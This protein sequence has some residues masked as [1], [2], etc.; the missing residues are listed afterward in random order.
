MT[1]KIFADGFHF[2]RNENAPDFVIGSLSVNVEQS[3]DT[4]KNHVK[5]GWL[6][7]Q[8]KLSKGGKYYVEVD[9]WEPGQSAPAESAPE[10]GP[11]DDDLPF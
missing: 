3:G 4:F 2:K 8:V 9:T 10:S 6:N 5:D 11:I 7:L 1:D